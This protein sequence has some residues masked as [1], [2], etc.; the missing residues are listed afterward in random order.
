MS[1]QKLNYTLSDDLLFF[2]AKFYV[3]NICAYYH[4]CFRLYFPACVSV[5]V[6]GTYQTE[7]Q[8]VFTQ[9]KKVI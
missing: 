4:M 7:G 5:S 8:T 1:I 6:R 3:Y 2:A 9:W